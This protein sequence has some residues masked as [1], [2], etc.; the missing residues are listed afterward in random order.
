MTGWRAR[1]V[2]ALA[3]PLSMGPREQVRVTD[4]R[5]SPGAGGYI[6]LMTVSASCD[7]CL[8][9]GGLEAYPLV[10]VCHARDTVSS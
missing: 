8:G 6:G 5:F 9:E 10:L 7:P 1:D 4:S 3:A 2:L